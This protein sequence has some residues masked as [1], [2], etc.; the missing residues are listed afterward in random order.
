MLSPLVLFISIKS[1]IYHI[2]I[3]CIFYQWQ[4]TMDLI[5]KYIEKYEQ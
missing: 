5:K 1:N 4:T 2:I 3:D